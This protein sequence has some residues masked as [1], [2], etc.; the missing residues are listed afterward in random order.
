MS[1]AGEEM[2]TNPQPIPKKTVRRVITKV[3]AEVSHGPAIQRDTPDLCVIMIDNPDLVRYK[4]DPGGGDGV[5][6]LV[7]QKVEEEVIDI[8]VDESSGH[9]NHGQDYMP[10][11][12]VPTTTVDWL[13]MDFIL[14]E[15]TEEYLSGYV[16][17]EE[18]VEAVLRAH[19]RYTESIFSF[20]SDDQYKKK[21][22]ARRLFYYN[23]LLNISSHI[24]SHDRNKI[25]VCNYGLKFRTKER[26]EPHCQ[27]TKVVMKEGQP[28]RRSIDCPAKII[29]NELS[30][31]TEFALDGI[32][33]KQ[34][35]QRM[36]TLK[37]ALSQNCDVLYEKYHHMKLPLKNAHRGHVV[38]DYHWKLGRTHPNLLKKIEELIICGLRNVKIIQSI[39]KK[40]AE[41]ELIEGNPEDVRHL[42]YYFPT[43]KTIRNKMRFVTTKYKLKD[44][45]GIS[46]KRKAKSGKSAPKKRKKEK[47]SERQYYEYE[48]Y[49]I[50]VQ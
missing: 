30:V 20:N 41:E 23:R 40:Y 10:G 29:V 36:K 39:L 47:E 7:E 26:E 9:Y 3:K 5:M 25:Y 35:Q 8:K 38:S 48:D 50:P 21:R 33:K 12:P 42:N 2:T 17:T 6:H 15:V 44:V 1:N 37:E 18:Q 24:T 34:R 28:V 4:P 45:Q 14:T 31:Y 27:Y 22:I 43:D 46:A 32:T 16:K 11:V 49:K 13:P 19:S